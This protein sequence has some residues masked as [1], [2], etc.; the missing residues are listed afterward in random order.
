M[1]KSDLLRLFKK[2]KVRESNKETGDEESEVTLSILREYFGYFKKLLSENNQILEIMAEMEEKASLGLFPPVTIGYIRSR[3]RVVS[4]KVENTIYYLNK[5]SGNK[6]GRLYDV[7]DEISNR[8]NE[9]IERKKE[10]PAADLT[11]PLEKI[12][13]DMADIVGG[14]MANMGEIMREN[15]PVPHGFAIS[16][17]AYKIF[18]DHNNLPE[19]ITR[20]MSVSD[21]NLL[22]LDVLELVSA[23]IQNMILEAE[24]PPELVENIMASYSELE[25]KTDTEVRISMRSSAIGEDSDSTF[26]GQYYTALNVPK[27]EIPSTYK[28]II[29]SKFTPQ[30]IFYWKNMGLSHEEIAMGVG[31]VAMLNAKASGIIYTVDPGNIEENQLVISAV[32][33]LGSYAVEGRV[34]PDIYRISK[35]KDK[36]IEKRA[37]KKKIMLQSNHSGVVEV[38]VAEELQDKLCLNEGQIKTLCNYAVALEKHYKKPQDIE[39]A[40][41][42]EGNLY[43]LQTRPLILCLPDTKVKDAIDFD[44][45]KIADKIL[46]KGTSA[47]RGVGWGEAFVIKNNSDIMEF[48]EGG[49]LVSRRTS[50]K[51]VKIMDKAA[52]IVTDI[53]NVTGHM[54]SLAREFNIPCIVDSGVATKLIKSG[55]MVTVD[56]ITG[57]VYEGVV[58]D[59]AKMK[60]EKRH[61]VIE[62]AAQKKLK[63]VLKDV[64]SLYLVDV[65]DPS[66]KE[67]NCSTFHD[68]TRFAHE[69]SLEEMFAIGAGLSD[70]FTGAKKLRNI[71]FNIYIIDLGGGLSEN[72]MN[73]DEI[74]VESI[75][76]APLKALWAGMTQEG[77]SWVGPKEMNI[78]GFLSAMVHGM[79]EIDPYG[80]I[81]GVKKMGNRN[82][83]ILSSNYLNFHIRIAYHFTTVDTYCSDVKN[84]NYIT[85]R[86]MGGAADSVRRARR[87]ALIEKILNYYD[88]SVTRKG[89]FVMARFTKYDKEVIEE[90]L[91]M[92]GSLMGFLR[93]L[94]MVMSSDEVVDK[95]VCAFIR[96]DYQY[97]IAK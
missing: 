20:E 64:A 3:V 65:S 9:K 68:I 97:S 21:S 84:D 13:R 50:P 96:G 70:K 79:T 30:A 83:M 61:I 42:A 76:S 93:Q 92:L 39:W 95:Y 8:I 91:S 88:F 75:E 2:S 81:V 77:I 7:H 27:E 16:T 60:F 53:G 41:D 49:V 34:S 74:G 14:K 71:P 82:Y 26:A 89:D 25:E 94:D 45:D 80:K 78:S 4:Q 54:A 5:I 15:V 73:L 46:V 56:A 67:E 62:T 17:Y 66:F 1:Y 36:I 58:E 22:K 23:K 24:M 86:F 37:G 44:R 43:L 32:W 11:I 48:P 59:L 72:A 12:T 6:Y 52:G 55:T 31:C 63:Q 19:K 35:D 10:V 38:N 33:G 40:M 51:Y 28:D 69:K 29:A 57:N 90:K 85:F 47:S 87:A 18:M